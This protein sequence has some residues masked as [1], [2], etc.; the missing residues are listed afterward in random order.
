M[1]L[2]QDA[3]ENLQFLSAVVSYCK[4]SWNDQDSAAV[5]FATMKSKAQTKIDDTKLKIDEK[6][7]EQNAKA[8]VFQLCI[9]ESW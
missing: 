3:D 4:F 7:E 1:T 5:K 2:D 9:N 8:P 6:M